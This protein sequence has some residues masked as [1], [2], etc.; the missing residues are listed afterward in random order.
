[1]EVLRNHNEILELKVP[2]CGAE[3]LK[4]RIQQEDKKMAELFYFKDLPF[5]SFLISGRL[6][7][8]VVEIPAFWVCTLF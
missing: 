7:F 6:I 4:I 8:P 3:I 2:V 1:M 5:Y